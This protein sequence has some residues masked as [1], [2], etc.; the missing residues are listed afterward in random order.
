MPPAARFTAHLLDG[1]VVVVDEGRWMAPLGGKLL[2]LPKP[3]TDDPLK[4]QVWLA[5]G[6]TGIVLVGGFA[7]EA[8]AFDL[9]A[10]KEIADTYEPRVFEIIR[11]F[12]P[13]QHDSGRF[14]CDT[15]PTEEGDFHCWFNPT[16]IAPLHELGAGTR[17]EE[18]QHDTGNDTWYFF[19]KNGTLLATEQW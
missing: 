11:P 1:Q 16:L 2:Y 15:P 3:I 13:N 17:L 18:I 10:R 19:G 14:V 4:K 9:L 7:S 5:V 6:V 8:E 12:H